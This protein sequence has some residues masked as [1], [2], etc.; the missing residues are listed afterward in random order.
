MERSHE[1]VIIYES[2]GF[3][4][5]V[6]DR[7]NINVAGPGVWVKEHITRKMIEMALEGKL[8]IRSSKPTPSMNVKQE[9]FLSL[10]ED[11][12]TAQKSS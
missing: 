9:S 1:E 5:C 3:S 6:S 10:I 7:L 12:T 4:R 2:D 8:H 11:V